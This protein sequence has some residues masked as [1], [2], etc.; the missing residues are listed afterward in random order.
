MNIALSFDIGHSSIGWA[1]LKP[2]KEKSEILGCGAVVFPKEDC[3]NQQ[4]AGFRRQRRHIAATRNRI[5]RLEAFLTHIGALTSE[6]VKYCRKHPHPWPW[7]LAAQVLVAKRQLDRREL[8]AVIRWYAHNRGYDGNV[9]W[10][11]EGSDPDDVKKVQAAHKLMQDCQSQSMCETICKLMNI[12]PRAPGNPEIKYYFKGENAAFP[13]DIVVTEIRKV[14]EQHVEVLDGI[15]QDLIRILLSDWHGA[16]ESGFNPRL[17]DRYFDGLLFG[18]MKP[19]FENRII[20]KC[21]IGIWMIRI[22]CLRY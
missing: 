18:Q 8:W 9:L 6:D 1:V 19:R 2:D 14:L 5:K 17:P 10:A 20:P 4:R 11:G 16:K 12:N 22:K 21:R 13:R 7:L 15:S 3:Q